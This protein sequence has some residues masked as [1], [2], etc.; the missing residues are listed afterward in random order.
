MDSNTG[1]HKTVSLSAVILVGWSMAAADDLDALRCEWHAVQ[2]QNYEA[3][4]K[5]PVRHW[6]DERH[7]ELFRQ[8][9]RMLRD[10]DSVRPARQEGLCLDLKPFF[11]N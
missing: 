3:L 9:D 6:A 5:V 4:E 7:Q 1:T 11:A 2:E 10:P 8:I